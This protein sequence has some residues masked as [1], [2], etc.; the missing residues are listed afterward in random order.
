MPATKAYRL[1]KT[2]QTD[3]WGSEGIVYEKHFFSLQKAKNFPS[4]KL[5]WEKKMLD[6]GLHAMHDGSMYYITPIEIL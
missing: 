4:K 6:S 2:V 1:R 5:K 3:G